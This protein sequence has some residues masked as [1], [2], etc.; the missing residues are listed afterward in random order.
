LRP[1]KRQA[2][3]HSL[4]EFAAFLRETVPTCPAAGSAAY[5]RIQPA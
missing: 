5:L 3:Q 4:R 1:S 2:A